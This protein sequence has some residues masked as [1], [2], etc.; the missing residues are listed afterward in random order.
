M[1]FIALLMRIRQWDEGTLQELLL[2]TVGIRQEVMDVLQ[3][4]KHERPQRL[5]LLLVEAETRGLKQAVANMLEWDKQKAERTFAENTDL[6]VAFLA[7]DS[8]SDE[9]RQIIREHPYLLSPLLDNTWSD[10]LQELR[11]VKSPEARAREKSLKA[12]WKLLKRL[13]GK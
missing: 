1:K 10:L 4:M 3:D 5:R 7:A 11:K 12:K 9:E 2:S 6:L 13:R 8:G